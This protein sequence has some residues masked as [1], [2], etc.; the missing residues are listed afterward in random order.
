MSPTLAEIMNAP[1]P[2][3]AWV[4]EQDC[5]ESGLD[6]ETVRASMLGRIR[7]MRDS[8]R[9]GLATDAPSITGMACHTVRPSAAVWV[10]VRTDKLTLKIVVETTV[11]KNL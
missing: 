11:R 2:A 4:L 3:S 6:A 8:I 1:P 7:E 10:R 9:R 5:A